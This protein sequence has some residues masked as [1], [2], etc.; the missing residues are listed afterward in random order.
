MQELTSGGTPTAN[1]LTGVGIDESFTRSGA[2]G[3]N[4]LLVDALGSTL[5]LADSSGTLQTH[6]TYESFG[7]TSVS[8][9]TSTNPV[10][11]TGRENDNSGLYYYR[12]RYYD[13]G[14][15]RFLTEDLL[16][17]ST[18]ADLY[19]YANNNPVLFVDPLGLQSSRKDD[20]C[21]PCRQECWEKYKTYMAGCASGTGL[22]VATCVALCAPFILFPPG[23][24]VC[25]GP[26]LIGV[27]AVTGVCTGVITYRY[28][29][30]VRACPPC[31]GSC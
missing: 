22:G 3:T 24:G 19:T 31:K 25:M 15:E 30:C 28:W 27:G 23:F 6:Y 4:T 18:G 2:G 29:E 14:R 7:A 16:G 12:F 1:L 11:F 13:P 8:G 10:Q 26:C 21:Q 9:A 17:R 20:D 5:E